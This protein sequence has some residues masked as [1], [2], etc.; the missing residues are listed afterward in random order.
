M[1]TQHRLLQRPV[2][3]PVWML[4]G[5][6]GG[7]SFPFYLLCGSVVQSGSTPAEISQALIKRGKRKNEE[8]YERPGRCLGNRLFK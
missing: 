4:L 2:V 1:Y 7:V 3:R 6:P 8:P 5:G